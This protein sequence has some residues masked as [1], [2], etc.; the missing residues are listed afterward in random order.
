MQIVPVFV[1]H[2]GKWN[3]V[4]DYIDF[5]VIRIT[6]QINCSFDEVVKILS[7]QLQIDTELQEMIIQYKVKDAYPPLKIRDDG[8][9]LFYLQLKMK[10]SDFT[11]F[12][13]CIS[14]VDRS[15]QDNTFNNN[16]M[17]QIQQQTTSQ[18]PQMSGSDHS[19]SN[20]GENNQH[21]DFMHY[22]N[23]MSAMILQQQ[24]KN[25]DKHQEYE[26]E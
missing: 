23:T 3:D 4:M 21:T 2:K 7:N 13:L 8:T 9:L 12:P 26:S 6:M 16:N 17:L 15:F 1:H 18:P 20:T 14:V 22:A 19:S 5:E 11:K 25:K 10:E 24:S